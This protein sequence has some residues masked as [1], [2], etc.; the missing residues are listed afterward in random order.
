VSAKDRAAAYDD[1]LA[2]AHRVT[3]AFTA[4]AEDWNDGTYALWRKDDL[5]NALAELRKV[6]G[7]LCADPTCG[8]HGDDP[9]TVYVGDGSDL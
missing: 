3:H 5:V 6:V 9:H 7:D 8:D 2:A 4:E 1:L